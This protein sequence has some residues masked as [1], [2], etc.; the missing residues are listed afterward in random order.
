M[1]T[2]L[3]DQA[4]SVPMELACIRDQVLHVCFWLRVRSERGARHLRARLKFVRKRFDKM[5]S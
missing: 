5:Q 1:T 2:E 3:T 4:K